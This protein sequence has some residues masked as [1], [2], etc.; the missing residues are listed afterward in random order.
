MME[1]VRARQLSALIATHDR[2]L[3]VRLDR[4]ISLD[5]GRLFELDRTT[6]A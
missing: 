5:E 2:G 3:A 4:S 1:L 6:R